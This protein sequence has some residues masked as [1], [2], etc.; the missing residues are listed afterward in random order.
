MHA[1]DIIKG[2]LTNQNAKTSYSIVFMKGEPP[3]A[4]QILSE[5]QAI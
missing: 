3:H 2:R 5:K 1:S 4:F